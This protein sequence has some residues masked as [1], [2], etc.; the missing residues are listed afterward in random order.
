MKSAQI[1]LP[2]FKVGDDFGFHLSEN[3]GDI[4]LAISGYCGQLNSAIDQLL[5]IGKILKKNSIKEV[6]ISGDTHYIEISGPDKIIDELIKKE[7]VE[8]TKEES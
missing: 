6:N 7:L 5:E 3:N 2:L 4:F 8:E 1:N